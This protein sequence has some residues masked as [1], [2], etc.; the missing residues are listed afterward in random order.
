V[1]QLYN[2]LYNKKPKKLQLKPGLQ[3]NYRDTFLLQP[4][5]RIGFATDQM[6]SKKLQAAIPLWLPFYEQ[7]YG[8]LD[9]DIKAKL[10]TISPST[11]DRTL[12]PVRVTGKTKGLSV[13]PSPER[14][15]KTRSLLKPTTGMSPN[16][17]SLRLIPLLTLATLCT[18]TLSGASPSLISAVAGRKIARSG[19]RAP[20][21][22]LPKSKI[23]KLPLSSPS[24]VLIA[25]TAPNS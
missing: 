7:E 23:L 16:Q 4:L 18:E 5:K 24:W 21:A 3:P 14:F 8:A 17:A 19:I 20:M 6:C 11:I 9:A 13:A 10:L 25:T 12:K 1:A 2:F 22:F 15:S